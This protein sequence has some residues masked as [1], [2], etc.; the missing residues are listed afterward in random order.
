MVVDVMEIATLNVDGKTIHTTFKF[1]ISY[2]PWSIEPT[3]K[4]IEEFVLITEEAF[5]CL[6]ISLG[7]IDAAWNNW[8]N[9]L[10]L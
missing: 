1:N 9:N 4:I 8:K 10:V 6:Q 7:S 2:K 5:I 3:T